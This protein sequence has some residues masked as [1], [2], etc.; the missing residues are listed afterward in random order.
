[1]VDQTLQFM[2]W[3]IILLAVG[4]LVMHIIR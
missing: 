1:P 4:L 3:A 2:T